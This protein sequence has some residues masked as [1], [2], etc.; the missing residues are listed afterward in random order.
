MKIQIQG[1]D[2]PRSVMGRAGSGGARAGRRRR[3][4]KPRRPV[5]GTRRFRSSNDAWARS[6][7]SG[8]TVPLVL[9]GSADEVIE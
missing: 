4:A 1:C 6:R 8:V 9:L 5:E 3:D 2:E 7:Q